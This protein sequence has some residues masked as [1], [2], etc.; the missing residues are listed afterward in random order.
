[1]RRAPAGY[2]PGSDRDGLPDPAPPGAAVV[3]CPVCERPTATLVPRTAGATQFD[4]CLACAVPSSAPV[5]P[6]G[7]GVGW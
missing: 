7:G 2:H 3:P 1:M 6:L 5:R 4:V